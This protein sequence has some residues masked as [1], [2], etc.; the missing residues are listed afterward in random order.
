MLSMQSTAQ[1][2]CFVWALLQV[3]IQQAGGFLSDSPQHTRIV[4][5]DCAGMF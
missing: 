4:L 5:Q 1:Q 3:W 2:Q